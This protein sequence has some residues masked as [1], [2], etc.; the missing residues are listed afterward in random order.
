[1][2]VDIVTFG[3][4]LNAFESEVMRREAERAGLTDAIVINTCAVTA[5]AVRRRGRRSAGERERP[6]A[7]RRHRLRG[8]DAAGDVRR[9]G[10]SRSR[11][12]Q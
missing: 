6:D 10:R 2:S 8:A 7:H 4:R 12:R 5:E 3:C 9:H 1:M 11:S